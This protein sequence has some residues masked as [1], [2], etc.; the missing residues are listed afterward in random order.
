MK[1]VNRKQTKINKIRIM[2][3]KERLDKSG[4]GRSLGYGFVEFETHEDALATLRATNNS[5][6]IF[7]DARRPI[8]EFSVENKVALDLQEKRR[9]RQLRR[10]GKTGEA[11]KGQEKRGKEN[12]VDGGAKEK[13]VKKELGGKQRERGKTRKRKGA[14]KG[15]EE[16]ATKGNDTQGLTK[17]FRKEKGFQKGSQDRSFNN[18]PKTFVAKKGQSG[19]GGERKRKAVLGEEMQ[20]KPAK[21][22]KM[23]KRVRTDKEEEKFNILVNKYKEKLFGDG[24]DKKK[25]EKRWYE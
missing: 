18:K 11:S 14:I 10:T 24:G 16:D 15:D 1:A 6:D 21:V 19:K 7:G 2:R 23:K 22:Q 25:N 9:E 17:K 20:A 12:I 13:G 8:V 4:K 5:P 3:S